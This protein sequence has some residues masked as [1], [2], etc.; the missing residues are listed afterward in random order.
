MEH[1]QMQELKNVQNVQQEHMDM[2]W[3][4]HH[5]KIVRQDIFQKKDGKIVKDVNREHFQKVEHLNALF[6]QQENLQDIQILF[7]VKYVLK[8]LFQN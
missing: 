8:E 3:E 4:C 1:F 7:H 5:V 2:L 6:V